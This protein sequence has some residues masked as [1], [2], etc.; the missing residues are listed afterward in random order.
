MKKIVSILV[1]TFVCV[2][3][4]TGCSVKKTSEVT[5]EEKFSMEY[6]VSKENPFSYIEYNE[7][8]KLFGEENA[9]IY[10]GSSN[11]EN[12]QIISKFLTEVLSESEIEYIYYFDPTVISKKENKKLLDLIKEK[13]D[14]KELKNIAIPSIYVIK[15]NKVTTLIEELESKE[16]ENQNDLSTDE[17]EQIKKR[18][19][20]LLKD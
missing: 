4:M 1:V 8:L 5:D 15:D 14:N 7:L 12:S 19:I 18:Y 11:D 17:K 16:L 20:K 6:D 9:I 2:F 3:F 10:F 13:S